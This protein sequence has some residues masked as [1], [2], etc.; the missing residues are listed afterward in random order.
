MIF[1][2]S[3][4]WRKIV[5]CLEH[6]AAK[7]TLKYS[8]LIKDL[9]FRYIWQSSMY[10]RFQTYNSVF[11]QMYHSKLIKEWKIL[12]YMSRKDLLWTRIIWSTFDLS[13]PLKKERFWPW[14]LPQVVSSSNTTNYRKW[15]KF[16]I[17][18]QVALV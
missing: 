11:A 9:Y 15:R 16:W 2:G 18:E 7:N 17:P 14:L 13:R 4:S 12:N 3:N 1:H 6:V 5:E 10:G 8:L